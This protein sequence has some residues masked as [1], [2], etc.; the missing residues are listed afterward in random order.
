MYDSGFT[1]DIL[2]CMF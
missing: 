1:L 2:R